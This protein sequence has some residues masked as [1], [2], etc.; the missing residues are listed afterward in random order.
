MPS[1]LHPN[2]SHMYDDEGNPVP[3]FEELARTVLRV[4]KAKEPTERFKKRM[5]LTNGTT[6]C[7]KNFV[8]VKTIVSSVEDTGSDGDMYEVA[9]DDSGLLVCKGCNV[10]RIVDAKQA[11]ASCPRCGESV[12]YQATDTSFREGTELTSPYLYKRSNHLRDHLKRVSA[13]QNT[14]VKKEVI[15]EITTILLKRCISDNPDEIAVFLGKV[16]PADVRGILKSL[17]LT[18]LYAHC[19]LVWSKVTGNKPPT[20]SPQK[21]AAILNLFE[22]VIGVWDRVKPEGRSNLLSYSFLLNKIC[23]LLDYHDIADYFSLLK[24]RSKLAFQEATWKTICTELNMPY[25]R[26]SFY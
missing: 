21:E 15:E 17:R 2:L 10:Q 3:S 18:K 20:L 4:R 24:S 16:T 8:S 12:W 1:S 7:I 23:T 5:K 9:Q 6:A 26:S 13:Q 14:E 19:T 11:T 25:I 22:M